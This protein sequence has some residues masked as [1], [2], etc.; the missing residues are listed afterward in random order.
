M[1]LD[2]S[3]NNIGERLITIEEDEPNMG[4]KESMNHDM[5]DGIVYSKT[6]FSNPYTNFK[7]EKVMDKIT[8]GEK[9]K[10]RYQTFDNINPEV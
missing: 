5:L 3:I 4:G 7:H 10:Q 1:V 8:L 2:Q 9:A 6:N